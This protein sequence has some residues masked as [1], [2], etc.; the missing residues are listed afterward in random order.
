MN[1][2][3]ETPI[4]QQDFLPKPVP[5]HFGIH[6]KKEYL[7]F[8]AAHFL[9]F[10]DKTSERLHGHNY[11]VE[12]E[13]EGTL[14]K[15]SLVYDF[16]DIKP[17]IKQ[18]CDELDEYIIL[19]G[20]HPDIEWQQNDFSLY[21][22]YQDK[23]YMFPIN[24]VLILPIDNTSTERFAHYILHRLHGKINEI[25][26]FAHITKIKVIVHES[27]GQSGYYWKHFS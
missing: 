17:L 25:F 14:A 10:P 22:T 19:P 24:E 26:S 3:K 5:E 15:G 27:P 13:I 7:K 16:L 2:L 21:V 8:S 6:L 18:I 23:K 9:I 12:A 20:N 1:F 4:K 11:Q